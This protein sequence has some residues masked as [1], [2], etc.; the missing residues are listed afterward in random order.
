MKSTFK[1]TCHTFIF[2]LIGFFS[3]AQVSVSVDEDLAWMGYMHRFENNNGSKGSYLEGQVWDNKADL[4]ALISSDGSHSITLKPNSSL[5][6]S[7]NPYWSNGAGDGNKW[8]EASTYVEY[9]AGAYPGG[10]LSFGANISSYTLDNR[11]TLKAFIKEFTKQYTL[12]NSEEITIESSVSEFN[13][14][15]TPSS[16]ANVIQY[17]FILEGLNAN[18]NKD[19]GAVTISSTS[20]DNSLV[21]QEVWGDE[22]NDSTIY[23]AGKINVIDGTKWFHQTKLPN[24]RSWYNSEV[25]HYTDETANSYV[26]DGTLKIVAKRETYTDK[27]QTKEFTSARLNSKFAFTYGKVEVRAKLP[28]GS[29]TWP[30]IW[31]LGKNI[32][33]PGAY[34]EQEFGTTSWPA[35]GEIDIM[36]HWGKNQNYV[37]SAM[38][39]PSSYGGTINHGGQTISTAS[40]KFHLYTLVWTPEKM[41]FSVDGNVHYTYNPTEKNKDTWPFDAD[42]YLLLNVAIEPSIV[43]SFKTSA[44]EIDYVRI[45]QLGQALNSKTISNQSSLHAWVNSEG[46]IK[47]HSTLML[48]AIRLYDFHGRELIHQRPYAKQIA[49][50]GN[51]YSGILILKAEAENKRWI[52]KILIN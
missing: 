16:N 43:S 32:T 46:Q 1:K 51:A 4:I 14:S 38:H 37:S 7:N 50:D 10:P 52:R 27:G 19:W 23:Q 13:M 30:A 34:W 12:V 21:Y 39:T 41:V 2:L 15:Y 9:A 26:S 29:G 44:M 33:E 28:T 35:C 5:Y 48:D 36:E 25:Q 11:Y 8:L 31:M 45:Y 20:N 18:P 47:I 24:G 3:I 6:N 40:S 49:V 42:Q 22:F 17:G